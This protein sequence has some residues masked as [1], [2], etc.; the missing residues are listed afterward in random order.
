MKSFAAKIRDGLTR[1]EGQPLKP[2]PAR[3]AELAGLSMACGVI[4]L[5]GSGMARLALRTQHPGTGRWIVRLIRSEFKVIPGLRILRASRL[6]GRTAFEIRVEGDDAMAITTAL[7]ISPFSVGIPK[8]CTQGQGRR[9]AFL[10]G[11]F[12]GCG[13]VTNPE[14][15]YQMEFA[16]SS[17]AFA[18]SLCGFLQKHYEI[19]AAIHTRKGLPVVY[20]KDGD[21]IVTALMHIGAHSGVLAF[22]NVRITKEA[23]NRAN[24]AANCDSGNITKMLGAAERQL[25][26]IALIEKTIGLDALPQTLKEIALERK[27]HADLSLEALGAL[28]EP[29]VGKSGVN[30]RLSRLEAVAHSIESNQKEEDGI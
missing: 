8:H 11:V 3:R 13:T 28:L 20:I 6:G 10:R 30:H 14:L 7:S 22:E 23:R 1:D 26:A 21:D 9:A 12:L 2:S 25:G 19:K 4:T 18:E 15:G 29:P 16:V 27:Q 24:R 17:Q 5:M